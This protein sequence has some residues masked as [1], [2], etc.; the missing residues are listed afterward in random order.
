VWWAAEP[1]GWSPAL[2]AEL[3]RRELTPVRLRL[4]EQMQFEMALDE[5]LELFDT[6]EGDL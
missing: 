2:L 4:S 3:P 5:L 1:T 6:L